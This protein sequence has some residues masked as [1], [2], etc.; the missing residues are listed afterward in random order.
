MFL[1]V[2][3]SLTSNAFYSRGLFRFDAIRES[4]LQIL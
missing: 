4:P 1:F 2:C 3:K